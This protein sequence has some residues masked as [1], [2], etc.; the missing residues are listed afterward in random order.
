MG[1]SIDLVL[2]V[3]L[4]WCARTTSIQ[5]VT[6]FRPLTLVHV[7]T[8]SLTRRCLCSF[9]NAIDDLQTPFGGKALDMPGLSYAHPTPSSP[10][11]CHPRS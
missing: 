2:N 8:S 3:T 1:A 9:M 7:H 5:A 10:P 4:V 11:S 6:T